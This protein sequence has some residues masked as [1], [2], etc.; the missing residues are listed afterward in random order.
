MPSFKDRTDAGNKLANLLK[1]QN[2]ISDKI[3]ICAI[4]NGGVPVAIPIAKKLKIPLYILIS[5]KIQYPWTTESG[6]GAITADGKYVLNQNALDHYSMT[7]EQI[8]KQIALTKQKIIERVKIFEKFTIPAILKG[9]SIILVDD[10]LASGITTRA[11]IGFLIRKEVEYITIAVP[12]AHERSIIDLKQY[13]MKNNSK[14]ILVVCP[15][16]RSGWSFAVA[17]A[18]Y[19]WYDENEKRIINLLDEFYNSDSF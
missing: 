17:D 4:P 7:K 14:E 15:D 18:Y 12:T 19:N 5:S 16:I 9:K 10:G 1:N 3:I 13:A 8:D 11:A 6:F 2:F